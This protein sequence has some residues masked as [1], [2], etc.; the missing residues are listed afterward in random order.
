VSRL[1]SLLRFLAIWPTGR[2]RLVMYVE[3]GCVVMTAL[4]VD[5]ERVLSPVT[6]ATVDDAVVALMQ[7]AMDVLADKS[8]KHEDP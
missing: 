1:D 3:R 6:R 2:L 4:D 7:S 8:G 5:N